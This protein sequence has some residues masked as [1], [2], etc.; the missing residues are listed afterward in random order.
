MVLS[1]IIAAGP[2]LRSHS[3]IRVPRDSDYILLSQIRDSPDLEGQVPG[4]ISP[5]D[6]VPAYTPRH[7]VPFSSHPTTRRATVEVF[8]P[9]STRDD[10]PSFHNNFRVCFGEDRKENTMY[11][12][13][14]VACITVAAG[15]DLANRCLTTTVSSGFQASCHIAPFLKLFSSLRGC[16]VG[17]TD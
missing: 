3:E 13:S 14:V 16:N 8:D 15:T 2:R 9:A 1:F 10:L 5:R 7:W 12:S 6:R 17:I 11:N 4:Y